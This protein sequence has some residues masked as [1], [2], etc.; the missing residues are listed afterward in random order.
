MEDDDVNDFIQKLIE[1]KCMEITGIDESGEFILT[2]TPKM[3]QL[4]PEIWS[5]VVSI[6]NTIVNELCEMNL[7]N[8]VIKTNG[9][10][11]VSPNENTLNY[12]DYDLTEEQQMLIESIIHR[13]NEDGYDIAND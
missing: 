6:T 10:T 7:V 12:L 1:E 11:F 4:Y 8:V 5:E 9:E 3:A 13:M 2:V